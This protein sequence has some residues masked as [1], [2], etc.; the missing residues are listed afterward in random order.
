MTRNSWSYVVFKA[1]EN[2][3]NCDTRQKLK[4]SINYWPAEL[5]MMK[6]VS[7]EKKEIELIKSI[8]KLIV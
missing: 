4:K 2:Q 1:K 7:P 5:E 6:M 8:K 3:W